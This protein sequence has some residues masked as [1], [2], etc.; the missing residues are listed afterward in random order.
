MTATKH[1]ARLEQAGIIAV[2]RADQ[3]A[4]AVQVT[5]SLLDGGIRAIELTFT[6]PGVAEA[7]A[8]VRN[9]YGDAILL[10]A[11]TIREPAQV[12]AAVQAGADFLVSAY[13][14][15]DTLQVMLATGLPTLPGVFTPAEVGRALDAGAEAVKIFP[16]STAGPD[17]LRA[18]RGPFPGLRVVPTGG[19]GLDNLQAWFA[20]GALAVGVGGEMVSRKLMQE[21]RWDEITRQALQFVEAA[22]LA[23]AAVNQKAGL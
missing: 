9:T 16:A 21:S 15:P 17:H 5:K 1:W 14:R 19:I 2:V 11:G 20:A 18:L 4:Q 8:E 13:I 10:G 23:R 7:M 22:R 12:E 6:T 3:P